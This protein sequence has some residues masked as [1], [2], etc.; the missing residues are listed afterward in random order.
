MSEMTGVLA[1]RGVVAPEV[2]GGRG[3]DIRVEQ[4]HTKLGGTRGTE[5]RYHDGTRKN[6]RSDWTGWMHAWGGG[7]TTCAR[8]G[9]GRQ[10]LGG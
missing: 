9:Y 1:C 6:G 5:Y 10:P 7:V 3:E 8:T 2:M 4:R